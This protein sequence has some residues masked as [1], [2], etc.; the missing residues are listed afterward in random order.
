[1]T[2]REARRLGLTIKSTPHAASPMQNALDQIA[3]H[4]PGL[5]PAGQM[6]AEKARRIFRFPVVAS[7]RPAA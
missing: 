7:N 5:P 3:E 6:I 2:E 4:V 1:M